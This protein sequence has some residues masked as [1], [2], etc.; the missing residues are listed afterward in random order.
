MR[1]NVASEYRPVRDGTVRDDDTTGQ[2]GTVPAKEREGERERGEGIGQL[3]ETRL[4]RRCDSEGDME[5]MTVCLMF[6]QNGVG[7]RLI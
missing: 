2:S 4:R 3:I 1:D 6:V 7:S 5:A